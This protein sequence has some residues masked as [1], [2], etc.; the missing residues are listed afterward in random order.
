MV[1]FEGLTDIEIVVG[2]FDS[3]IVIISLIIG[4]K[5][6]SKYF[7]NKEI[8]L[9]TVGFAMIFFSL[10]FTGGMVSFI[11]YTHQPAAFEHVRHDH[12]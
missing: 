7:S 5:L 1:G 3:L 10:G 11:L 6:I 8:A 9:V 12:H 2:I 4:L